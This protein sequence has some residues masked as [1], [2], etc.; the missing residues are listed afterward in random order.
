MKSDRRHPGPSPQVPLS[1]QLLGTR[2][3]WQTRSLLGEQGWFLLVPECQ[4][5]ELFKQFS[6]ILPPEPGLPPSTSGEPTTSSPLSFTLSPSQAL[7]GPALHAM[8][9][10][11]GCEC[12]RP[13]NHCP[14][15]VP[16][17][18]CQVF[19]RLHNPRAGMLLSPMA[20]YEFF[21]TTENL[22]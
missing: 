5:A 1:T 3:P 18:R 17:D 15:R 14:S 10:S 21:R 12:M 8:S 19:G 16:R 20:E 13:M 4:A 2:S 11:L 22:Q 9:P 7:C 6:H